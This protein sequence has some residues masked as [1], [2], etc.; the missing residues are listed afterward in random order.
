MEYVEVEARTVDEAINDALQKLQATRDEVEITILEEG[1]KG[2][3][4]ILGSKLARVRVEKVKPLH[5]LKL[6][7]AIEYTS[8]LLNHMG[9]FA[10]VTGGTRRRSGYPHRPPWTDPGQSAVHHRLSCQ[11]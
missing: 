9:V 7:R 1:T 5:E 8:E 10:E 4:G 11:P 6:E 3:L 2:F